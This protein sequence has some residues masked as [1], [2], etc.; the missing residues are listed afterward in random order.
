MPPRKHPFSPAHRDKGRGAKAPQP[1]ELAPRAPHIFQY[2]MA[3]ATIPVEG[4]PAPYGREKETPQFEGTVQ[5]YVRA[6]PTVTQIRLLQGEPLCL[7]RSLSHC[8]K[9]AT[10]HR[11]HCDFCHGPRPGGP[12]FMLRYYPED[13]GWWTLR[14]QVKRLRQIAGLPDFEE[15]F[16]TQPPYKAQ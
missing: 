14:H 4:L 9:L 2:S 15:S 16:P 13:L 5:S 11:E 8:G 10:L 7:C 6:V 12:P 1:H 3:K